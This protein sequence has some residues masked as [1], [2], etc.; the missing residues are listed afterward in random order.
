[1]PDGPACAYMCAYVQTRHLGACVF[2]SLP[3]LC[4]F[5][6]RTVQFVWDS[7]KREDRKACLKIK[8]VI[9][10]TCN[11]SFSC[12]KVILVVVIGKHI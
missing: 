6:W 7:E 4:Q 3:P 10:R 5:S 2:F 11:L 8:L 9:V 12:E 1:M